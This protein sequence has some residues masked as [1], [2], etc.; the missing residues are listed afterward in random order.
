MALVTGAILVVIGLVLF[1]LGQYI[2]KQW[3]QQT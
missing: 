1:F 2:L 3:S